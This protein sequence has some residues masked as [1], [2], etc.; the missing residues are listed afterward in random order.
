MTHGF[1]SNRAAAMIGIQERETGV[2]TLECLDLLLM[3]TVDL[4][5][6]PDPLR[7]KSEAYV[8]PTHSVK[9]HWLWQ[10]KN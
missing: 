10:R 6:G 4:F 5:L 2:I 9:S 8:I 1:L 3:S 7:I